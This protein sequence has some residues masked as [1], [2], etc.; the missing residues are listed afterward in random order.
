MI[1]VS[2]VVNSALIQ[3]RWADA[4]LSFA[5]IALALKVPRMEDV[6]GQQL[7]V[8]IWAGVLFVTYSLLL[9]V[10]KV[11]NSGYP[12]YLPPF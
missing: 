1:L 6:K 10:F 11:K 2:Y 4:V 7:A 8:L 9:S 3:A 12:F 5:V